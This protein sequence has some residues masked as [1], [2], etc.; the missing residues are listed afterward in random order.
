MAPAID[1]ANAIHEALTEAYSAGLIP[2]AII[3]DV[4]TQESL[5]RAGLGYWSAGPS[6]WSLF[7][8]PVVIG[9]VQGWS[10]DLTK[11]RHNGEHTA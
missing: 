7:N 2:H 10:L 6:T 3:L 9:P 4:A 11:R 8:V 5:E 1:T